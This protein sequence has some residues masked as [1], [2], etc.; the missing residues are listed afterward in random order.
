M[1][2]ALDSV[3]RP[4]AVL[5]LLGALTLTLPACTMVGPDYRAPD[6][7][8]PATWEAPMPHGGRE[9]S[10]RNWW[11][12][13]NDKT[14]DAL[15]AAA[16][17]DSPTLDQAWANI[18][19][20]RANVD[21]ARSGLSPTV[22]ANASL[23]RARQRQGEEVDTLTTTR[24]AGFDASWEIDL[25]GKIRRKA[26]AADARLQA[27]VGDWHQARVSLAAEVAD[28]YVQYRGCQLLGGAY[29]QEL[30]SMQK[31]MAATTAS[32][33]A[34]FTSPANGAL[35]RASLASTR[36]S[37]QAQRAEC[38]LLVKSL[39]ALTGLPETDLRRQLDPQ[40]SP[41]PGLPVPAAFT[42]DALP[43][44]V[45]RQ[46]PDIAALERDLAATSASIG[47]AQ[48]DLYPS[49]TLSGSI[50]LSA[51]QLASGAASWSFGP[52]LS[53]PFLDG[54]A[55]RAAVASAQADYQSALAQY[56]QGVRT[57]IKEVEQALVQLDG[58]ASRATFAAEAARDY[59]SFEQATEVQWQAGGASL[60]DLEE[61][62]RSALNADIE[63]I[64]L[65]RNQVQ[66]W[67]AL[68]KAAGGGW[69]ADAVVP[70]KTQ[71]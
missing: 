23:L 69:T 47:A 60:L 27:R 49:L 46:R 20:A 48:A 30:A 19:S 55:R 65:L 63:H 11:G 9:V 57:A 52:A 38:Q 15:I 31:T 43:A 18:E 7:A 56:R 59:R 22:D 53:L 25:F 17:N 5:S 41:P 4:L 51:S 21:T 71:P 24:S 16:M 54:G 13:F 1:K 33:D 37:L 32:V 26:Q 62:R 44:D 70:S 14:L 42:L 45:L 40:G 3:S 2:I 36:A 64:T 34:G 66:Y 61:A 29:E 12:Q 8:A 58:A 35:A 39:V 68:Y 6:A 67:I 28:D 10:L 50:S